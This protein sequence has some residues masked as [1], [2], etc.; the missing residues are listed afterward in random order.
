MNQ[1]LFKEYEGIFAPTPE[2]VG[3]PTESVG[4][5]KKEKVFGYS[6]F[7]LQ[8]AIGEKNV[9]KA[10]IEYEKLRL[11]GIEAEELIYKIVSKA[12]HMSAIIEGANAEDL[13][14]KDYPYSKSKKDSRNW[15]EEDLKKFY[16]KLIE[17]HHKSRMES[18]NELDIS[19]EKTL[20]SI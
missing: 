9:K 20:L 19:L 14:I 11:A 4:Q 15:R 6:P 8:D 12:M 13:G 2:E 5:A 17:I 10:W 1:N 7:A 18:N 16:T 3:G